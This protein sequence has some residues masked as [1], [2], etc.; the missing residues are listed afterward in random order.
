MVS[1]VD[2]T[3]LQDVTLMLKQLANDDYLLHVGE[4]SLIGGSPVKA[5]VWSPRVVEAEVLAE[6][7]ACFGH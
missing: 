3:T 1:Y 2:P 4:V 5:L 6:T 7:V